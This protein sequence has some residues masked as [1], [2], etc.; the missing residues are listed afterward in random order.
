MGDLNLLG[1]PSPP[2]LLN[3]LLW[4]VLFGATPSGANGLL[5]EGGT[6][7]VRG[8]EPTLARAPPT[9]LSLAWNTVFDVKDTPRRNPGKRLGLNILNK[10]TY[11]QLSLREPQ[12]T[13]P[14]DPG[15]S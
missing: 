8:M 13:P 10:E 3:S 4:F 14:F 15:L 1:T 2:R 11:L 7:R 6:Y 12:K 5:L 9:V